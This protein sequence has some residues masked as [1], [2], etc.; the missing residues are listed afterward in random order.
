MGNT[1]GNCTYWDLGRC[2][3]FGGAYGKDSALAVTC[4]KFKSANEDSTIKDEKKVETA[5]LKP[6]VEVR[7]RIRPS[8]K[9]KLKSGR[10]KR[11]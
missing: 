7:R 4:S 11:K 10:K 5:E 9:P 3:Q 8:P 2:S 6:K 1:C